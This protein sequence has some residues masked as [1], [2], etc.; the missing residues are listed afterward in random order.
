VIT[1]VSE[2]AHAL[3]TFQVIKLDP[4]IGTVL[5]NLSSTG[6]SPL[7]N[8]GHAVVM[9]PNTGAVAVTG[10]TQNKRSLDLTVVS[11]T[12]DGTAAWRKV[13]S[14]VG[15][16]LDRV[17]AALALAADPRGR[18]EVMGGYTQ[19]TTV[20]L[21]G[22][23]QD[24]TLVKVCGGKLRWWRVLNDTDPHLGNAVLAVAFDG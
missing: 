11:V 14:G 22:P 18:C 13:V 2:E 19:N 23:V 6:I 4:A 5:W 24:F 10:F 16:R 20:G 12:A 8:E 21:L 3:S 7:Y 17:D 9:N 15:S 1:G